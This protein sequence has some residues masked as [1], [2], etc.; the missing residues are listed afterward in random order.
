[1]AFENVNPVSLRNAITQCKNA[2]NHSKTDN[3]INDVSNSSVW[4]C[5]SQKNLKDALSKLRDKRYKELEKK[6][7]EYANIASYI[8]DYKDYEKENENLER[9]YNSLS[10]NLYYWGKKKDRWG[11]YLKDDKGNYKYGW[12][13]NYSV[14]NQMNDITKQIESNENEMTRLKN[15]VSNSI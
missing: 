2:I 1:M 7:D 13:L 10:N 5:S 4:Q 15:K 6:L 14:Q 12:I 9:K 11:N 3:L 8:S